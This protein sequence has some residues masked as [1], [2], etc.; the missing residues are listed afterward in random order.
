MRS[1]C[2]APRLSLSSLSSGHPSSLH[3]FYFHITRKMHFSSDP[4]QQL[5]GMPEGYLRHLAGKHAR[6]LVLPFPALKLPHLN[7]DPVVLFLFFY[8]QMKIAAAR[9]LG[10]MGYTKELMP[11]GNQFEL[12]AD[13]LGGPSADA[14]VHLIEYQ[15]RRFI[16]LGKYALEAEH[17]P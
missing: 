6:D 17:H 2:R 9:Y 15:H 7:G 4:F 13:A 14:C 1:P 3:L 11:P 12:P 5:S 8:P 16:D 10:Q